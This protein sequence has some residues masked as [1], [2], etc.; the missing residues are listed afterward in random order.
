MGRDQ[1]VKRAI[2]GRIWV[3]GAITEEW[4]Y[5]G[6]T[7][8]GPPYTVGMLI[9]AILLRD[10][11]VCVWG[12]VCLRKIRLGT[13]SRTVLIRVDGITTDKFGDVPLTDVELTSFGAG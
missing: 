11:I 4:Y 2:S 13:N 1:I 9:K 7:F 5:G 12:E 8:T 6:V 3:F 10:F